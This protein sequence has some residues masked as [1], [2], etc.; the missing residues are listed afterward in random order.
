[1]LLLRIRNAISKVIEVYSIPAKGFPKAWKKL[2]AFVIIP[3]VFSCTGNSLVDAL[4]Y[5]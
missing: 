5:L 2:R 3:D 4:G 1:M